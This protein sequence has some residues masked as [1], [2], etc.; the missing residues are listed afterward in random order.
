MRVGTG[1]ANIMFPWEGE[2]PREPQHLRLWCG[3][4]EFAS[5][6]SFRVW[7]FGSFRFLQ[8]LSLHSPEDSSFIIISVA[9]REDARPPM[10]TFGMRVGCGR[11]ESTIHYSF[12][13]IHYIRDARPPMREE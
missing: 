4:R 2:R 8:G 6:G 11:R 1:P 13:T 5:R 7:Q 9:A 3:R 12:F 10:A